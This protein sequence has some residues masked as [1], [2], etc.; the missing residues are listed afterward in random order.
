MLGVCRVADNQAE[1]TAK[2]TILQFDGGTCRPR[3]ARDCAATEAFENGFCRTRTSQD[4]TGATP[5]FDGGRCFPNSAFATFGAYFDYEAG[6]GSDRYTTGFIDPLIV[7]RPT[8]AQARADALAACQAASASAAA[9]GETITRACAEAATGGFTGCI[10]V[11]TD[12]SDFSDYFGLGD[13]PAAARAAREAKHTGN[14]GTQIAACNC[15]GATPIADSTSP[16]LCRAAQTPAECPMAIPIFDGGACRLATNQAECTSKGGNLVFDGGSCRPRVAAD[17]TGDTPIFDGGHCFPETSFLHGSYFDFEATSDTGTASRVGNVIHNSAT[18]AQARA[19]ALAF[20]ENSQTGAEGSGFTITRQCAEAATFRRCINVGTVDSKSY[21]GLGDTPAAA[22]AARQAK[23][24]GAGPEGI[25][26]C[27]C[28]A[29]M[30]IVDGSSCRAAA[31]QQEC[32]AAIPRLENGVCQPSNCAANEIFTGSACRT[33]E[34]SDCTGNTP[35]LDGGICRA[36]RNNA[37]CRA[38]NPSLGNSSGR[39]VEVDVQ[40]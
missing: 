26:R 27:N 40:F 10:N 24:P 13:T 25:S 37:E 31:N 29:G 7:N 20:C 17:C 16:T 18:P 12:L 15:G 33:R 38:K 39:C 28:G 19:S 30:P 22:L 11:A 8:A 9:N 5:R 3:E 35:I 1:C 14:T 2:D 32:P 23:H 6:T 4:C 21:F 36:A 34:A